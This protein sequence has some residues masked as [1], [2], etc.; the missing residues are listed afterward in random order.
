MPLLTTEFPSLPILGFH[1]W[2]P[3]IQTSLRSPNLGLVRVL[4]RAIKDA[5][6]DLRP[7]DWE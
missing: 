5:K 7:S 3:A 2:A 4:E 1:A 6:A